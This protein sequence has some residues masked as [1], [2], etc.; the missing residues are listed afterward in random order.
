MNAEGPEGSPSQW[1]SRFVSTG[2]YKNIWENG[3]WGRGQQ[4]RGIGWILSCVWKNRLEFTVWRN[5]ELRWIIPDKVSSVCK[6]TKFKTP[7]YLW[8]TPCK[9]VQ[10]SCSLKGRNGQ[11]G[12]EKRRMGKGH[13]LGWVPPRNRSWDKDLKASGSFGIWSQETLVEG[14]VRTGYWLGLSLQET[15]QKCFPI[16]MRK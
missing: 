9:I 6:E 7:C 5:V 2:W 15:L 14:Q 4:W 3:V 1:E 8:G 13:V 12:L 11:A 16:G 10:D